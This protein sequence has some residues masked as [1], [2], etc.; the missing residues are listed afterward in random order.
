MALETVEPKNLGIFFFSDS[1]IY[2]KIRIFFGICAFSASRE[3]LAPKFTSNWAEVTKR[4]MRVV[5]TFYI[6]ETCRH[7]KYRIDL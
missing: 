1:E 3:L 7:L 2:M 6:I 4:K 5:L